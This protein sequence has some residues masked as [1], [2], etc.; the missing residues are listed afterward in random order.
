MCFKNNILQTFPSTILFAKFLITESVLFQIIN[1]EIV[2]I[3]F[4]LNKALMKKSRGFESG[5]LAGR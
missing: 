1:P 4:V 3:D 2:C 5:D